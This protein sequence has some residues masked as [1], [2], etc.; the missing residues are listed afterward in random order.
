M[1]RRRCDCDAVCVKRELTGVRCR[2]RYLET[3]P[4][5][6]AEELVE[7]VEHD[8]D[9][10]GGTGQQFVATV[11]AP[12]IRSFD[13]PVLV[14]RGLALGLSLEQRL[15]VQDDPYSRLLKPRS[16]ALTDPVMQAETAVVGCCRVAHGKEPISA[17]KCLV[18]RAHGRSRIRSHEHIRNTKP[19]GPALGN[20]HYLSSHLVSPAFLLPKSR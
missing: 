3:D 18:S 16:L 6:I 19:F 12:R 5:A 4:R 17:A 7:Q 13:R 2:E 10:I 11:E 14:H 20:R 9:K 15:I 8:P 1:G